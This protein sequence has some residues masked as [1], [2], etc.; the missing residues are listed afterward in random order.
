MQIYQGIQLVYAHVV[1]LIQSIGSWFTD[2]QWSQL[3]ELYPI[4]FQGTITSCLV[5]ILALSAIGCVKKLSFLL[6]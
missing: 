2:I 3:I 5:V 6:G 4:N 1:Q